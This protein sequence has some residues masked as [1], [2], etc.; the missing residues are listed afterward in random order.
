[1]LFREAYIAAA[2]AICI[3]RSAL[4]IFGKGDR[5][6]AIIVRKASSLKALTGSAN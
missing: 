2:T 4:S 5:S 1:V 3:R 6:R